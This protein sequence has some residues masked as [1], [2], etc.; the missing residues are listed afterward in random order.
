MGSL[1]RSFIALALAIGVTL[2]TTDSDA[3]LDHTVPFD[4]TRMVMTFGI[5]LVLLMVLLRAMF[6]VKASDE[7]PLSEAN[8]S[9]GN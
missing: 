8:E 2:L 4:P 7:S 5:V 3:V 1:T 9:D 6:P